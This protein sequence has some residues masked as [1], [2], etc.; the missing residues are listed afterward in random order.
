MSNKFDELARSLAGPST[1]RQLLKKFGFGL[2]AT[3]LAYF[4]L[5]DSA[6]AHQRV[7]KASGFTCHKGSECCSGI[8]YKTQ[9]YG[10]KIG[11]CT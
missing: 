4:G 5:A 10:N 7:C 8:C 6:K 1:R 2:A 3:A 9:K 11:F